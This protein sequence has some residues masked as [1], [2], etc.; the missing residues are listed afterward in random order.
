M[1]CLDGVE[2]E[3][4]EELLFFFFTFVVVAVM[5]AFA[6]A[7][8]E[9]VVVVMVGDEKEDLGADG[10]VA[11]APGTRY[12]AGT[13]KPLPLPLLLLTLLTLL[14]KDGL[15][16]TTA[17]ELDSISS[18]FFLSFPPRLL[19]FFPPP[20]TIT[21]YYFAA[22]WIGKVLVRLQIRKGL[23]RCFCINKKIWEIHRS[24]QSRPF[25]SGGANTNGYCRKRV[26][27]NEKEKNIV[28]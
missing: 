15:E 12:G 21:P 5:V 9:A 1:V 23:K 28:K 24:Y 14:T 17:S 4:E 6:F 16:A 3:E 19:T 27:T 11:V 22:H 13:L 18:Q 10:S 25:R 2:E 7:L 8:T 20:S 26:H